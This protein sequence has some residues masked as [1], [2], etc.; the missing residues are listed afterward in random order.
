MNEWDINFCNNLGHLRR[1]HGMAKKEMAEI[2][3][4]S[5]ATYRKMERCQE[6]VRLNCVMVSRIC[7][8]FKVSGDDLLMEN[9]SE[10]SG[11]KE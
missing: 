2:L 5:V 7:N 1:M 8:H 3:G 10:S 6:A 9:M 11:I 4:V